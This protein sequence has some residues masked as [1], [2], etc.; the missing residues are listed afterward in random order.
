MKVPKISCFSQE[1][2]MTDEM[3]ELN[4]KVHFRKHLD[5][6]LF[7]RSNHKFNDCLLISLQGSLIHQEN[8]ELRKKLDLICQEN[9]ELRRKVHQIL[10]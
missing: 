6:H 7:I 10:P 8:I 1:Q 3:K 5:F 9:T 4:Q 2:I